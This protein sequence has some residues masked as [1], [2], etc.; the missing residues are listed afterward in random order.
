[1]T[2]WLL[3]SDGTAAPNPGAIG[4]GVVVVAPDGARHTGSRR[5]TVRGCNTAAEAWALT[6]GLQLALAQGAR[7][8]QAHLD[9]QVVVDHVAHAHVVVVPRLREAFLA[10]DAAIAALDE[11]VLVW[12]PRH[13]N[14]EADTLARAA[15]GLPPKL[16]R[17]LR[18][19]DQRRRRRRR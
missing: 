14:I 13:D 18:P 19:G 4:V 15:L 1:M 8:V 2:P 3:H 5:L 12:V 6:T 7:R 16:P 11:V 9:S 17:W 10:V